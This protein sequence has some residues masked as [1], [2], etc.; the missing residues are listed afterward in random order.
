[1]SKV[2]HDVERISAE[3]QR[4]LNSHPN[5]A[6]SLE[7]I[8]RWWLPEQLYEE[9]KE[10]VQKALQLLVKRKLL[11]QKRNLDGTHIYKSI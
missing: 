7:G 5:A 8:T 3:I 1:M 10:K 2:D 11:T 9:G 4:Y 6:D